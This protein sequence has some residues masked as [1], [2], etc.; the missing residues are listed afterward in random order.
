MKKTD[1]LQKIISKP[2]FSAYLKNADGDSEKAYQ[3]YLYNLKVSETLYHNIHWLEL[4]LRNAINERFATKISK[5]WYKKIPRKEERKKVEDI[6]ARHQE[7]QEDAMKKWGKKIE[8]LSHDDIVTQLNFGFWCN[9][10]KGAYKELYKHNLQY[11]FNSPNQGFT[12]ENVNKELK[13][14]NKKLKQINKIRNRI[15][16]YE[17][18]I[19]WTDLLEIEQNLKNIVGMIEPNAKKYLKILPKNNIL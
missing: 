8:D 16:H 4:G 13:R 12:R 2:R 3:L 9:L 5:D 6:L 1:I 7:K 11:I 17:P 18:I 14:L 10:F 15:A 19:F